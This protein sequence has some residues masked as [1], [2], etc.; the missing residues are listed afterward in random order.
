MTTG[1]EFLKPI[2][3]K[4]GRGPGKKPAFLHT[5]LR[6]PR[7]VLDYFDTHFPQSKQTKIREILVEYVKQQGASQ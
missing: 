2:K 7:E 4:K 1:I 6:L 5:S 3:Q